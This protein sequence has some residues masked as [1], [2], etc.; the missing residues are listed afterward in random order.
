MPLEVVAL[1]IP[2]A[3]AKRIASG[4]LERSGSIVRDAAS[5]QIVMWLLEGGKIA[6]N[7]DLAGGILKTVLQA[8]SG[9]MIS[10]LTG[11]ANL[12]AT[13][14]SH[15]MIMQNL[16]ALTNLVG[17]VGGVGVLNLAATALSTKILLDR[18]SGLEKAINELDVKIAK[19]FAQDRQVKMEAAIQA[20]TDAIQMD[21]PHNRFQQAHS[22][23]DK[24]FEARQHIWLEIDTLK[25]S[26]HYAANNELMQK[27]V[28]QAMQL[29][30]LR[31]RC[32]L[33][34]GAV[35]QAKAYLDSKLRDFLETS[36]SLVHRHL[37]THRAAYFHNSIL[38]SDLL[39][40]I[41]I[42]HWLQPDS[43]RLLQILL[44]NRRD[45]WNK[46][47]ADGSKINKP[48]KGRYIEA[49]TQSELLIENYQRFK[50]LH[51]EIE[52]IER[53]GISHS[54]WEKQQEE[55]LAKAEINLADHND[56]VALV[57]SDA[58]RQLETIEQ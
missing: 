48:G 7:P 6:D 3:I 26:S 24:L 40:Y 57:D 23:I 30:S 43:N 49:L 5:K 34:L 53:L 44:S 14:H 33:E 15:F 39:R 51:A 10:T 9:G 35:P 54:E 52:A 32:L 29:D 31:S 46:E 27:N 28:L 58:L 36:R 16:H 25:G 13:A 21:S 8:S 12:A 37:G 17:I 50:G 47:V 4:E 20:A 18:L 56:Y 45:F 11:A 2:L 38:E 19:Q 1:E 55:A 41:A 22:A 42:E